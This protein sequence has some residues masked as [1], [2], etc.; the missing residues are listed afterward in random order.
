MYIVDVFQLYNLL[1]GS[2][3]A[4]GFLY[5]LTHNRSIHSYH[6]FVHVL[7]VGILLFAVGDPIADL[8]APAWSHAVH[9]LSA[10]LV[11][12]GLYNPIHNDLRREEW[13]NLLLRDPRQV[14][15]PSEW[16]VPMD[17]E[18]LEL[19]HSTDL[20]LTPSIIA[21]N[22]G[23]SRE[24]VNRR[25]GKMTEHGLMERVERGKYRI[26]TLGTDYLSGRSAVNDANYG[27]EQA[28]H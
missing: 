28:S 9:T 15:R 19:F 16:M 12:Y 20:V 1:A 21:Y 5:L 2:F 17:D 8:V 27:T 4:A 11:I 7:F 18:I 26:T 13:S 14:R 10:V 23:Y 3:T 22:T 25:L 6:R 24:E